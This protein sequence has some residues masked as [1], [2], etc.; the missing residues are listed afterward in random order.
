MEKMGCK[1][2]SKELTRSHMNTEIDRTK[3][4]INHYFEIH[5]G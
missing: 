5:R 2:S 4:E 3:I 1:I